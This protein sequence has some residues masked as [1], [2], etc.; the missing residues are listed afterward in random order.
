MTPYIIIL[1][2]FITGLAKG[3]ETSDFS[4]S[5]CC[6]N[7]NTAIKS[8]EYKKMKTKIRMKKNDYLTKK[9]YKKGDVG[10][11]D[12]YTHY[13]QYKCVMVVINGDVI[14]ITLRNKDFEV[15]SEEKFLKLIT[16]QK[17]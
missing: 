8:Y 9:R 10:Y 5:K 7:C 11:I 6:T 15:I 3:F 13:Y 4:T 14:S 12:G 2:I 16:N 17:K 1:G